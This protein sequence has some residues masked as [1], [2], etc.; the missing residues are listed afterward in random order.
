M[1]GSSG[2]MVVRLLRPRE[3][4]SQPPYPWHLTPTRTSLESQ[5]RCSIHWRRHCI[6]PDP[7]VAPQVRQAATTA[8]NSTMPPAKHA[9]ALWLCR[10]EI[11]AHIQSGIAATAAS[12]SAG[13]KLDK[14]E[15]TDKL[16]RAIA[17]AI[18]SLLQVSVGAPLS[19]VLSSSP[20]SGVVP[21]LASGELGWR[22]RNCVYN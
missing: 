8:L 17:S 12:V 14:E 22:A 2:T 7:D 21:Y 15:I 19:V 20:S 10:V 9:E 13:R 16:E 18:V 5:T 4:G 11:L 3:R 1:A 6:L